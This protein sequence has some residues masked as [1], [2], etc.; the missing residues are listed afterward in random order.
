M[1]RS[2]VSGLHLLAHMIIITGILFLTVQFIKISYIN[3]GTICA[4]L[5]VRSSCLNSLT[6]NL[7]GIVDPFAN[8]DSCGRGREIINQIDF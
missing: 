1:R 5:K 2:H 8:Y 3:R 7:E 4:D 6:I